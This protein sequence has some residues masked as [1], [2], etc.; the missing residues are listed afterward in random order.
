MK[1][2]KHVHDK[3]EHGTQLGNRENLMEQIA[4]RIIFKG[5]VQGVGFRFTTRRIVQRYDLTGYV[6]NLP[7]GS[8]E[9]LLQGTDADI[10]TCMVDIQDAFDGYIREIKTNDQP[11]NPQYHDFRIAF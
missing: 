3:R 2:Q 5:R 6:K 8:V 4:E 10:Q 11:V 9:A 1:I 7:D